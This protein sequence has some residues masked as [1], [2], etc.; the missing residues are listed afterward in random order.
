MSSEHF[1]FFFFL[2]A[3]VEEGVVGL[4]LRQKVS[5]SPRIS[6][7]TN[8]KLDIKCVDKKYVS[9]AQKMSREGGYPRQVDTASPDA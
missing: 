6:F 5:K 1:F 3:S 4:M 9:F 2:S 7:I 8:K